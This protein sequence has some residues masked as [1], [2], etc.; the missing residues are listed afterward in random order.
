MGNETA[1]DTWNL[2]LSTPQGDLPVTL[3]LNTDGGNL[4]GTLN[5]PLGDGT[6]SGGTYSDTELNTTVSISFQGMPVS[7]QINGTIEGD[8]I[9]GTVNTGMLGSLNFSGTRG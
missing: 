2:T 3:R 8:S 9:K 4:S 5:T 1:T 6:I 7:A